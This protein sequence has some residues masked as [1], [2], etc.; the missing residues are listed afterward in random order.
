VSGAVTDLLGL[1]QTELLINGVSQGLAQNPYAP[2]FEIDSTTMDDCNC[3]FTVRATNINGTTTVNTFNVQIDNRRFVYMTRDS[4]RW[5]YDVSSGSVATNGTNPGLIEALHPNGRFAYTFDNATI[6]TARYEIDSTTGAFVNPLSVNFTRNRSNVFSPD[7][8]YLFVLRDFCWEYV[9]VSCTPGPSTGPGWIKSYRVDLDGSLTFQNEINVPYGS[10]MAG[11]HPTKNIFYVPHWYGD[12]V[13][14][15]QWDNFGNISPV[16][17]A[18][19]ISG[20]S[21]RYVAIDNTGRFAYVVYGLEDVIRLYT[22]TPEGW[23]S[24]QQAFATGDIP[25]TIAIHNNNNFLYVTNFNTNNINIFSINQSDGTLTLQRSVGI[26]G[27]IANPNGSCPQNGTAPGTC[28]ARGMY[29]DEASEYAIMW[30]SNYGALIAP[31]NAIDG[32]LGTQRVIFTSTGTAGH[33]VEPPLLTRG[34]ANAP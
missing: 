26:D 15:Y 18:P 29:L 3:D 24:F 10:T 11:F 28:R 21:P 32:S 19:V 2:S 23:L 4:G 16:A 22:I 14:I 30:G 6:S 27:N 13:G 7:G 25:R 17:G 1:T 31:V 20:N 34:S 12:R 9:N 8:N 33:G 5:V